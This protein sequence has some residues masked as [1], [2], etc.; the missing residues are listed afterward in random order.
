MI[1]WKK[2]GKNILFPPVW[3]MIIL[4]VLCAAALIAV[5]LKGLDTSPIAYVIYVFSFYTLSV[6]TIS[7][8]N[9]LPKQYN[10]FKQKVYNNQLGNRYMT[11]AAFKVEISLYAS[12]T[13]NVL[14]SG[15]N[16]F[17]GLYYHSTWSFTLAIYYILLSVMRFV[18][19]RHAKHNVLGKQ[20]VIELKRYRLC[21]IILLF[22]NMALSGVVVLI[23]LQN[24]GFEYAGLLIYAMAAHTFFTLVRAI[25]NIIKY[26]KYNSPVMSASKAVSFAAA[27]VSLLALETAMLT[28]FD[29]GTAPPYFKQV[30]IAV[31]GAVVCSIIVG[32]AIYMISRST[33]ELRQIKQINKS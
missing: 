3:L 28:Q 33:K 7:C 6:V 19:L 4:S 13:I 12:L 26:R 23:I 22:M 1:N 29:D 20:R 9:L 24:E 11:D 2:I 21:G 30:M 8:V 10:K 18:L 27:L 5:F 25:V 17:S 15:V 31:T 16:L 14:Y 32:M